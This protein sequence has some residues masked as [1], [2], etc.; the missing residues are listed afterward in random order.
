MNFNFKRQL[1][2]FFVLLGL[3]V[4]LS[5]QIFAQRPVDKQNPTNPSQLL[6]DYL[7]I[8]SIK[9]NEG[10]A[11]R[12]LSKYCM[13]KGLHVKVFSEKDS[14]YNFSASL[15]PLNSKKPNIVF[16]NH[17]DVIPAGDSAV[18]KYPPFSG[19]IINNEIWGRGAI[20]CKGLAVMQLA[21]IISFID[22][23]KYN[24]LP[25]NI[26][27]LSVSGEE[28]NSANGAGY[29]TENFLTELNP[30]VVFGE[31][32]S[33]I[34]NAVS[35]NPEKIIFGISLSEKSSLLIKL[36]VHS[37][38]FGHSAAPSDLY[39]NKKLIKALIKLMEAKRYLVFDK[40]LLSMFK[41]LGK[42]EGGIKGFVVSH[43]N[44]GIFWPFVKNKF[45]EGEP[46]NTLVYNTFAITNIS[47]PKSAYNQIADK[48]E[49]IIDCR[50][51]PGTDSAKFLRK[52]KNTLGP[53]VKITV[54][55]KSPDA[56]P[57]KQD[58]FFDIFSLCLK[59]NY[60]NSEVLPILFPATTDNNYFRNK[61]IDVYG[62]IPAVF[63]LE[64]MQS[65]HN[66]NERIS[67][68]NLNKGTEVFK[69]FISKVNLSKK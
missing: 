12:F 50:L 29:I 41:K 23:A 8:K 57:S 9:G 42:M 63:S 68:D 54:L 24:N 31:G 32:G 36:E 53:K 62:I 56:L 13:D 6:S 34:I 1:L 61:N 10:E 58:K 37:E 33:G 16:I 69:E 47:N 21:A 19:A 51:L 45:N 4:F 39:A 43:I 46:L 59:N 22:S 67:I 38:S 5:P 15:Y 49:A 44:W 26:T 25:Y 52:L 3:N 27:F 40:L 11:G 60:K 2:P 64:A 14:M 66:T 20:D 28:T 48:A 18:W 7:K 35:S 65:V 55:S 30:S 17:I